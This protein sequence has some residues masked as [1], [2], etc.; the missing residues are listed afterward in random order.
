MEIRASKQSPGHVSHNQHCPTSKV[1]CLCSTPQPAQ[2]SNPKLG[3]NHSGRHSLAVVRRSLREIIARSYKPATVARLGQAIFSFDPRPRAAGEVTRAATQESLPGHKRKTL[4]HQAPPILCAR[5][6]IKGHT[7]NS[8]LHAVAA[9]HPSQGST[10]P[11]W[12]AD[13]RRTMTKDTPAQ[14]K[15]EN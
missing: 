12:P 13:E 9:R 7:S 10:R 11:C 14:S 3:L 15:I 4:A 2:G 6:Q 5:Q 1:P 8:Q